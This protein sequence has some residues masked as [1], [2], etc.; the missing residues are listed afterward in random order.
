MPFPAPVA[1]DS[2][3]NTPIN[4]GE[5]SRCSRL[6]IWNPKLLMAGAMTVTIRPEEPRDADD[7]RVVNERA[8][9]GPDEAAIVDALRG[10]PDTISIVALIGYRVVG[11]IMLSPV[12][13]EGAPPDVAVAGLAPMA[14][15]PEY[16][17]QGVGSRLVHAG[18]EACRSRGVG[19]VVV[20]GHPAYYPMFGFLRASTKGLAYEHPVPDE[21]FMVLEL[22]AGALTHA[23]GIVHFRP[24]FSL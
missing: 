20:V 7:V 12:Q 5:Y 4:R 13:I 10:S 15:L 22:H 1:C 18:L 17:R 8:F 14:V 9:E 21:V 11:H 2:G 24:E 16:Q 6:W 3:R 19:A 23:R